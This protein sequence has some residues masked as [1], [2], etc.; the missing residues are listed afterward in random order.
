VERQYQWKQ[1][2]RRRVSWCSNIHSCETCLCC[3]RSEVLPCSVVVRQFAI[4]D[5]LTVRALIFQHFRIQVVQ[6]VNL[7]GSFFFGIFHWQVCVFTVS[8]ML[9][10]LKANLPTADCDLPICVTSNY[11]SG[12]RREGS[13]PPPEKRW[14]SRSQPAK[15][16]QLRARW[17]CW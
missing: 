3:F 1:S 6:V 14:P 4:Q 11:R 15:A 2:L 12:M 7:I 17:G 16:P 10:P 8:H 5:I 13:P 9:N